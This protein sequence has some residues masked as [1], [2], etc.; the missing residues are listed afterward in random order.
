MVKVKSKGTLIDGNFSINDNEVKDLPSNYKN[1]PGIMVHVG[2]ML[3]VVQDDDLVEEDSEEK[4]E[5][6]RVLKV[7]Q[8]QSGQKVTGFKPE[9]Y[10]DQNSH[11]VCK[12]LRDTKFSVAQLKL[13][14]EAEENDKGRKVVVRLLVKK[15]RR[16][17]E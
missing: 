16:Y 9:V 2:K 17:K 3:E 7:P 4:E 12:S 6:N 13:L 10:L 5:V 14:K 8:E 11:T 15:I 1:R